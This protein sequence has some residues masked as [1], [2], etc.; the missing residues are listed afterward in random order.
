M[1]WLVGSA[2][3][4]SYVVFVM[5]LCQVA[6]REPVGMPN[7]AEGRKDIVKFHEYG[8][9]YYW[10]IYSGQVTNRSGGEVTTGCPNLA[11]A[12]AKVRRSHK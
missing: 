8:R 12:R 4:I 9:E 5:C 7:E 1:L 6:G 10:H 11:T 2:F 3:Y